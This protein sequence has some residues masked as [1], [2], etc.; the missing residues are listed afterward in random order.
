[1]IGKSL[2]KPK[3]LVVLEN[4]SC[5]NSWQPYIGHKLGNVKKYQYF[6]K[7]QDRNKEYPTF[8]L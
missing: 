5:V 6:D 3:R 7:R 1:M 2:D 8:A 4:T